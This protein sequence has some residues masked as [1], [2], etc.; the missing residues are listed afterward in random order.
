MS[1]LQ[2]N[3]NSIDERQAIPG[4]KGETGI[5]GPQ[6]PQGDQGTQGIKGIRSKG[7]SYGKI[8][9]LKKTE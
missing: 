6:G 3:L 7:S 1:K 5:Q 8:M 2:N 9:H 4:P